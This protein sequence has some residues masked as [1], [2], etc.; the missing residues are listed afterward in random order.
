MRFPQGRSKH[1]LVVLTAAV[2]FVLAIFVAVQVIRPREPNFE[3]LSLTSWL[4]DFSSSTNL[5][6]RAEVAVRSMGTNSVPFLLDILSYKE[7]PARKKV[8]EI[9]E[10]LPDWLH[11]FERSSRPGLEAAHAINALG[12]QA[13]SAFPTLTNLFYNGKPTSA[14][15]ALA[16]IGQKG[17]LFLVN[18]LTNQN[19]S[20]R[21]H[22]TSALAL[23]SARSDYDIVVPALIQVLQTASSSA[24]SMAAMSLGTLHR[25][26]EIAVPALI[27]SLND[28]N[29]TLRAYAIFALGEFGPHAVASVPML[30]QATNDKGSTVRMRSREALQKISPDLLNDQK[31][32]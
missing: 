20:A 7:S 12:S 25:K 4:E 28:P 11:F 15:I 21:F 19:V 3:G 8:R 31:V 18:A 2:V 24:R 17:V 5:I 32:K 30:L 6:P 26:P 13:E 29:D 14:G 22:N 10:K 23:G 16:G 1:V 9:T 27:E